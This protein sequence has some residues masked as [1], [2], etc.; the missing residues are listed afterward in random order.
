METEEKTNRDSEKEKEKRK[1]QKLRKD[2]EQ[3]VNKFT[4]PKNLKI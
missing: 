1:L 4:D 2:K 3:K